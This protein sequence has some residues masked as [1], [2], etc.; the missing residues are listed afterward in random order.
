MTTDRLTPIAQYL[1]LAKLNHCFKDT[2]LSVLELADFIGVEQASIRRAAQNLEWLGFAR[3]VHGQ[4][5]DL[6][7]V[8]LEWKMGKVQLWEKAIRWMRK[9]V[10]RHYHV[11]TP[12]NMDAFI[13]GGANLLSER[14]TGFKIDGKPHLVYKGFSQ[15]RESNEAL[16]HRVKPTEADYVVEFWS[17]PP[18]LPGKTEMDNLSLYLSIDPTGDRNIELN[19]CLILT[20]FDWDGKGVYRP[21]IFR[22]TK[23]ATDVLFRR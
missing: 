6:H 21:R 1:I 7:K 3:R 18:L 13:P 23:T 4:G 11:S 19:H 5:A 2:H 22:R 8:Y 14:T 9:P 17:H 12:E 15:K 20:T 10:V 16:I